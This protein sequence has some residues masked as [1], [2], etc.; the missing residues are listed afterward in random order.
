[1]VDEMKAPQAP[2]VCDLATELEDES[3]STVHRILNWFVCIYIC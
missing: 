2:P 3:Y 1:M